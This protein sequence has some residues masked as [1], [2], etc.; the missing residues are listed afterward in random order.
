MAAVMSAV[1]L[2]SV[3]ALARKV[4]E[5]H[6]FFFFFFSGQRKA[7]IINFTKIFG[8]SKF[9]VPHVTFF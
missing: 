2:T 4:G 5:V 8:L 3:P 7:H 9:C 1:T 6:D